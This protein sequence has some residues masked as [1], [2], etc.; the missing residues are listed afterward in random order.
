MNAADLRSAYSPRQLNLLAETLECVRGRRYAM[1]DCF[2]SDDSKLQVF[3]FIHL[4]HSAF[5][6]WP[7]DA[8]AP[9]NELA[10][11]KASFVV[12]QEPVEMSERNVK[13]SRVL[14]FGFK[15][16]LEAHL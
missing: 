5:A 16:L 4:A 3:R 14:L 10:W 12:V 6:D 1:T 15:K 2:E 13:R 11:L 8:E 7:N 9:K